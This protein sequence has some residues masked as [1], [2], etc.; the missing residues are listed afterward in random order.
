MIIHRL[1]A[2]NFLKYRS[3]ELND[4][5]AKGIIAVS[6]DNESGKSAIGE[7]IC[8]ALFGRTFAIGPDQ[9]DKFIRWG[10]NRASVS[11]EFTARDD[12]RYIVTRFVDRDRNHS[13]RLAGADDPDFLIARGLE[14][15]AATLHEYLGFDFAEYVE[16]FYLAQREITTTQ[17]HSESVKVMAGMLPMETCRREL[18][19]EISLEH[20]AITEV[21]GKI[22]EVEEAMDQL[23]YDPELLGGLTATE[24]TLKDQAARVEERLSALD[25]ATVT[26]QKQEPELRAAERSKRV[27]GWLAFLLLVVTAL[28]LGPWAL[29]TYLP[30]EPVTAQVQELLAGRV[31]TP[32]LLYAGAA[33]GGLFL[34]MW[35]RTLVLGS[36]VRGLRRAGRDLKE[37]WQALDELDEGLVAH[38]EALANAAT[39]RPTAESAER[40]RDM[41]LI[42]SARASDEDVRRA[43]V[44]DEAWL[45]RTAGRLAQRLEDVAG[46]IEDA[47]GVEAEYQR[48]ADIK[49]GFEQ[50]IEGHRRR[51]RLRE[52]AEN[53]VTGALRQ[54]S[55]NFTGNLRGLAGVTLPL[56][57]EDRY[58][59]IMIDDTLVVRLFSNEKRD[60]MDMDEVS[61][62]TQR[63]VLL[64]L[65]LALA[66]ELI[67]RVVKSPQ[68]V[69]LDE[70][71][72]FFDDTRMKS[73][74]DVLPRLSQDIPQVW[75]TSQNFPDGVDFDRHIRVSR[76]ADS[77]PDEQREP[78]PAASP[79]EDTVL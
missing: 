8:F 24:Q 48:L 64:A 25:A 54:L 9:L 65:R 44:A 71:F 20:E 30:E 72:A 52:M 69:F 6:G 1:K 53:L 74:L 46:D 12:R 59:H 61:T 21:E 55:N 4:L 67:N 39:A 57:T 41:E 51:I 3:L 34:L 63:Q 27:A 7:T 11:L 73:A 37:A 78:Q 75:V 66:Q 33:A 2:E 68:F 42:G 35:I 56:F 26:Y 36:K 43:L 49:G 31:E 70:P 13:V 19:D 15:V 29:I 16:A 40:Q 50:Q 28:A 10:E 76:D 23:G 18:R 45:S 17:S 14:A 32:W 58:Q 62:G 22:A 5:P 60:Y 79:A 38:R 77:Y 47:R